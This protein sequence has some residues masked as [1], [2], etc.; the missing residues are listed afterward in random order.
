MSR[1]IIAYVP[2]VHAGYIA[3]FKRHLAPLYILG[4]DIIESFPRIDRDLRAVSAQDARKIVQALGVC[5]SVSILNFEN[6]PAVEKHQGQIILPN[7]ELS[8][9][10]ASRHFARAD[11]VFETVFLRWDKMAALTKLPVIPDQMTSRGELERLFMGIAFDHASLSSDWWR[12][13]GTLAVRDGISLLAAYN[14][15]YP[16]EHSP[17]IVGD[18]RANFDAGMSIDIS[19]ALHAE[20]ILISHAARSGIR[21]DGASIYVTT[22]PC[23]DCARMIVEAGIRK[24]YYAEGYSQLDAADTLKS[25][26]VELILVQM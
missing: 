3:F 23:H 11:V 6:L 10:V 8:R 15:H 4:S 17:G 9:V 5:P 12:R 2:V 14:R 7:D 26:G 20:K 13:V 19:S 25:H 16:S 21:L 18:P 22:F 24:V 1:I